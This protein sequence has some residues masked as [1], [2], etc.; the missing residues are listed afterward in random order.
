MA[1]PRKSGFASAS[2]TTSSLE[3]ASAEP[4]TLV[5][6]ATYAEAPEMARARIADFMICEGGR[7]ERARSVG[8]DGEAAQLES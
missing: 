5:W 7:G 1:W 8:L 4:E 2:A 6:G 3:A